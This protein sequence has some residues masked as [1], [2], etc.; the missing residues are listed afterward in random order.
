VDGALGRKLKTYKTDLV[1]PNYLIG[2]QKR[3]EIERLLTPFAK[4]STMKVLKVASSQQ[5][6]RKTPALRST[7][8]QA[9]FHRHFADAL[10]HMIRLDDISSWNT[11]FRTG[12]PMKW[13]YVKFVEDS[14]KC[15]VLHVELTGAG[16]FIIS[17]R[18][19][20]RQGRMLLEEEFRTRDITVV[21]ADHF[22]NL[23]VGLADDQGRTMNV[24]LIQA[25]DFK[26]QV[27]FVLSPM[28]TVSPVKIV[29]FGSMRVTREGNELGMV[30]LGEI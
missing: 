20:Q 23:L 16:I 2:I 30:K 11:W 4:M 21:T 12:R 25:I 24:G 1:R 17:E 22:T 29:Q 28:K 8:R 18:A 15:R 19:C 3:R 10:G 6:R 9:N 14:L 26:Q 13:Q 7:R 5:A 27:M